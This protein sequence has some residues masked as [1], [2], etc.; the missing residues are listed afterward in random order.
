MRKEPIVMSLH[1]KLS[2]AVQKGNAQEVKDLADQA[3]AEG[4]EVESI[5]DAMLAGMSVVGQKFKRNEIFVPEVLISAR[6]L[7]GGLHIV[8]PLLTESGVKPKG[9][10][11]IG[12]VE[13]DLHD[14]GKNLVKMMLVGAG[15]E[16]MD[17]G[18]DVPAAKFIDAA[19]EN[20][21]DV[22]CIS[23]LLTTTMDKMREI[24]DLLRERGLRDRFT[25]MV[26]GAPVNT[27]FAEKIGADHYAADAATAAEIAHNIFDKE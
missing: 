22:I 15:L 5:L 7:N 20:N 17:L 12:T 18:V 6:A 13:G 21:V 1:E 19:V 10:A 4:T 3:V 9:K 14:I 26:G 23:A 25:V 2:L 11:I 24:L 16:V 8:K 27:E